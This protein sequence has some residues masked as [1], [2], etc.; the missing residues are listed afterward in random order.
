MYGEIKKTLPK[1]KFIAYSDEELEIDE[2]HKWG[3]EPFHYSKRTFQKQLSSIYSLSLKNLKFTIRHGLGSYIVT[4]PIDWIADPFKSRSWMH[5]FLSLRW[6][7]SSY[8]YLLTLSILTSF[9]KFHCVKKIK[10]PYYNELRGDHTAALR[11]GVLTSIEKNIAE[12]QDPSLKNILR[13]LIIQELENLQSDKMY[14][15]GHNHG[16]MVDLALLDLVFAF[17]EYQSRVNLELVLERSAKSLNA[18]WHTSGLTKEHS[19]SYQEYNLT[20]TAKYFELLE[21]LNI[22]ALTNTSLE[23]IF[24][25][26]KKFLGYALKESGEYFPL[27][28]SFRLPNKEILNKVFGQGEARSSH[29]LLMPYSDEEG[30]YCNKNFFIFRKTV[31]G[32]KVHF[33]ATC[34]WD[35][36]NHKQNDELSFCLEI[37][38]ATILDDPGYTEFL[39]WGTIQKLQKEDVHSTLTIPGACWSDRKETN[40]KSYLLA[41]EINGGFSLSMVAE[42]VDGVAFEREITLYEKS[43]TINDNISYSLSDQKRLETLINCRFVLAQGVNADLSGNEDGIITLCKDELPLAFLRHTTGLT[44]FQEEVPLV[45]S[46]RKKVVMT[47]SLVFQGALTEKLFSYNIY[48]G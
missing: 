19:V 28:D 21:K 48:W 35:S 6:L 9:Y 11:L 46:D 10:N 43:L 7:N 45:C 47:T 3:M 15:P 8:S 31:S 34:C 41:R 14:R 25:E 18:M 24:S 4:F 16:L 20:L 37:D 42:R 40:G 29:E 5:H 12:Y 13:R 30:I 23:D 33:A 2:Q 44:Y 36:H 1:S 17:T 38:G 26:S 32:S 39:D 22:E 27:G